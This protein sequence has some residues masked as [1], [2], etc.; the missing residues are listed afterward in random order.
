MFMTA[1]DKTIILGTPQAISQASTW[2]DFPAI[3]VA[4]C[5]ATNS[6]TRVGEEMIE[7]SV[8]FVESQ[9]AMNPCTGTNYDFRDPT[10]RTTAFEKDKTYD[11]I[12]RSYQTQTALA[13]FEATFSDTTLGGNQLAVASTAFH[14]DQLGYEV[15]ILV[16]RSE[17]DLFR[18]VSGRGW[19]YKIV[20]S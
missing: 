17:V 19:S 7:E 11:D 3:A 6:V 9:A 14:L 2:S 1:D 18:F 8:Y 15:Q 12:F 10:E 13:E 20:G 4:Q 5:Y 16:L